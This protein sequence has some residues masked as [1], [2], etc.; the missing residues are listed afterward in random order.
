MWDISVQLWKYVILIKLKQIF[1]IFPSDWQRSSVGDLRSVSQQ[2]HRFDDDTKYSNGIIKHWPPEDYDGE[3][4]YRSE[5]NLASP[6]KSENDKK[7][8]KKP[9]TKL[10][11][12]KTCTHHLASTERI[13]RR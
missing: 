9:K 12:R 2:S 8:R 1:N 13:K 4:K 5:Q 7:Q 10:R 6:E 3:R 11:V